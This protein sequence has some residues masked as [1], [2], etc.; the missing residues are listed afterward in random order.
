M[1]TLVYFGDLVWKRLLN[2]EILDKFPESYN[3]IQKYFIYF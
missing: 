1:E 2:L 3:K